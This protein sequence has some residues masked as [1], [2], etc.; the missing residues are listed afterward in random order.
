MNKINRK[1]EYALIGLKHMR[2]KQPGELT[3]VKEI[4]SLYGCPFEA[5]SKVMQ[6][7]AGRGLI[8]SE[9]GAH[10]GYQLVRDLNRVS[11]YEIMEMVVGPVEIAKCLHESDN[12]CDL[13]NTCNLVSPITT[14]NRRLVEF[15]KSLSVG[16]ILENR[17]P[18]RA[19]VDAPKE[20][21][22]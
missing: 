22:A 15:Y 13:K 14:L 5:T 18:V 21:R 19:P 12:S 20:V 4:A 9:Q 8:R 6:T 16:E 10:G 2:A 17:S 3:S 11:L 7:L 1:V